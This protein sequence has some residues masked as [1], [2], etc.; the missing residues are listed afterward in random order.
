VRKLVDLVV[1]AGA[2]H[3]EG[4]PAALDDLEVLAIARASGS[5]DEV[6]L[7]RPRDDLL[8][9]V[10][11]DLLRLLVRGRLLASARAALKPS[12]R[13]E[14]DAAAVLGVG[15]EALGAERIETTLLIT[16][17]SSTPCRLDLSRD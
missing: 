17:G 2:V 9:L 15:V 14:S 6:A 8:V 16:R 11:G 13:P 3:V 5:V 12:P 4:S 10:A 1:R 7:V